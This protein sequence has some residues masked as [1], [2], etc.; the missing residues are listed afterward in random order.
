MANNQAFVK[1]EA[2]FSSWVK[3]GYIVYAEEQELLD[4]E[5]EAA[6]SYEPAPVTE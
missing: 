6:G 5:W 3:A 1:D 4:G 2:T